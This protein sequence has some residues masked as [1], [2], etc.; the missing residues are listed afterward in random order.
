[1][2]DVRPVRILG[3]SRVVFK[4]SVH[5]LMRAFVGVGAMDRILS[6]LCDMTGRDGVVADY[7]GAWL[8]AFAAVRPDC[9]VAGLMNRDPSSAIRP[10][11]VRH[12]RRPFGTR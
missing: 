4:T 8:E 11:R 7:H 6:P 2:T 1:M 9:Q 12:S 5:P 10:A 3:R